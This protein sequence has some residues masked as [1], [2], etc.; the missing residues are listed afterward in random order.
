M[1]SSLW[2]VKIQAQDEQDGVTTLLYGWV[3]AALAPAIRQYLGYTPRDKFYVKWR[4]M[5][6]GASRTTAIRMFLDCGG[7]TN[8]Q[9]HYQVR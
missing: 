5:A 1:A 3:I 6:R 7:Y 9:I 4:C 2:E 8:A